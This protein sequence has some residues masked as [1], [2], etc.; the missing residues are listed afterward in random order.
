[1]KTKLR[2]LYLQ[3]TVGVYYINCVTILSNE[4]RT[5]SMQDF[6]RNSHTW[7]VSCTL[8]S[9][10]AVKVT[11]AVKFFTKMSGFGSVNVDIIMTIMMIVIGQVHA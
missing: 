1:M 6:A 5:H 10:D 8:G 11:D 4:P 3:K 2:V 7:N 9:P